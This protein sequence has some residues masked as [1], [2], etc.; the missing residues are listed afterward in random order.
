MGFGPICRNHEQIVSELCDY[1]EQGCK[2]KD[3][4]KERVDDFFEYSDHDN[5]ARIY[6]EVMDFQSRFDKVNTDK[7][8]K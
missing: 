5:C 4:Y 7:Y 6:D 8:D 1:I 3:M 2:M